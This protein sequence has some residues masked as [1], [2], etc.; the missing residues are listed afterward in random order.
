METT[1]DIIA[2]PN[3]RAILSLLARRSALSARSSGICGCRS[4]RSPS[5]CACCARRGSWNRARSAAAPLSI[6]AGAAHGARRLARSLPALLVEARRCLGAALGPRWTK[7]RAR[8]KGRK[9]KKAE[10]PLSNTRRVPLPAPRSKR[11]ATTGRSFS[12][13]TYATRLPRSGQALTDPEHLREWAPFDADRSLGTRRHGQADDGRRADAASLR[14]SREARR[15]AEAARVQ[16]GRQRPP[17]G[18]RAARQRH[19]PH[20]VAQ[21]RSPLHLVG[22]RGLAHL[23]RRAGS[24]SSAG[25]PIGRIVGVEAM[26]FE[27]WQRLHAEYAQQF[28]IETPGWPTPR[29]VEPGGNHGIDPAESGLVAAKTTPQATTIVIRSSPRSSACR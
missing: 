19:A 10:Q 6:A 24:A 28:G 18:A 29:S 13:A 5:T 15:G 14:N 3:R 2:E 4:R 17:V 9:R 27:G 1:F 26:K 23:L 7:V 20:A 25:D 11:T 22:R 16:L 21:H 8:G 12:S